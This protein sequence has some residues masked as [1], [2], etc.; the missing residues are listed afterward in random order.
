VKQELAANQYFEIRKSKLHG[1]G[2]FATRFIPKDTKI[3]KYIGEKIDKIESDRRWRESAEKHLTDNE[4]GATYIFELNEEYDIDGDMPGN[5]AKYIN[6]SC[7]PNCDVDV[8]ND[9]I[10]YYAS[11]DI[12]LGEELT[13]NYSYEFTANYAMHKCRCGSKN[14]IGYIISEEDKPK[15]IEELKKDKKI[16]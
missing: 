7:E 14:C 13:I 5:I 9:E 10:W 15:L 11:C 16:N 3:I 1:S 6:H 2:A 12:E 4:Y 8:D